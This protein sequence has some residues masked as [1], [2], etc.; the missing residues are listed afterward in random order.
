M[1]LCG[2]YTSTPLQHGMRVTHWRRFATAAADGSAAAWPPTA[3]PDGSPFAACAVRRPTY[4][5][6]TLD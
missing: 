4:Y 5:S 1:L 3:A 6:I 2:L